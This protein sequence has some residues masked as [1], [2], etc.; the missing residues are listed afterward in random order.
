LAK[1]QDDPQIDNYY[2]NLLAF[3]YKR[4]GAESFEHALTRGRS[5]ITRIYDQHPD[6]KAL[7]AA[8]GLLGMLLLSTYLG[9]DL[10]NARDKMA[11]PPNNS[12]SEI[13]TDDGEQ[14]TCGTLWG[15]SRVI[16]AANNDVRKPD[17]ALFCERVAGALRNRS[18]SG[19][20]RDGW[21]LTIALKVITG[22]LL[23]RRTR[24]RTRKIS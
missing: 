4:I 24:Y 17:I 12:I 10:N 19:L 15:L 13:D 7:V 2:H 1:F 18:V 23:R 22:R 8:H 20:G 21:A 5:V 16:R 14:F 9:A 6:G 3:D 11:M